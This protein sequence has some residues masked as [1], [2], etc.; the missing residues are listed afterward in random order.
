MTKIV[1]DV[2]HL[3]MKK[4]NIRKKYKNFVNK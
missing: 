4:T 1:F 2:P 3:R